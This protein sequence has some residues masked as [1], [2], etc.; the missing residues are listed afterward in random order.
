V[1]VDVDVAA[2]P[3]AVGLTDPE[4]C[5]AFAVRVRGDRAGLAGA[6]GS[7]GAGR[8]DGDEALIAVDAVRR[9]AAGRVGDGWE[10]DFAAMLRY[11]EGKGWIA[12]GG[13]SIRAHVE[14]A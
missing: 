7:A 4:D 8:M 3:P 2:E 6:L 14:D 5:T 10:D 9:L 13:R 11:A 12:D 1:V